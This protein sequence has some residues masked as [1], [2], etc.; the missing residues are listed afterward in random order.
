MMKMIEWDWEGQQY[1]ASAFQG[2]YLL[3]TVFA[4]YNAIHSISYT[5]LHSNEIPGNLN[6]I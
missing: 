2:F 1:L 3:F 4:T 6:Q 5:L